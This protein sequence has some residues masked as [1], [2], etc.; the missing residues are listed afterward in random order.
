M[1]AVTRTIRRWCGSCVGIRCVK[2]VLLVCAKI[3]G[4]V[5]R[6]FRHRQ[7]GAVAQLSGGLV[8]VYL[9]KNGCG[10]AN[11]SALVRVLCGYS[12]R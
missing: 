4:L 5:P 9:T 10:N 2:I 7:I 1:G 8:R 6:F 11:Y 12:L 3:L